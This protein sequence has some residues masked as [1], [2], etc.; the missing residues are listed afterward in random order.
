MVEE[1]RIPTVR[2]DASFREH[3]KQIYSAPYVTRQT[4]F[5]TSIPEKMG[6]GTIIRGVQC[7]CGRI[8]R[9]RMGVENFACD[10]CGRKYITYEELTGKENFARI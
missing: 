10:T 9:S 2:P 3:D 8:I 6:D 5:V 4:N 7:T 1:D